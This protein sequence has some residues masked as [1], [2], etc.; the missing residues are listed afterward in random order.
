MEVNTLKKL[1]RISLLLS[2]MLLLTINSSLSFSKASS[3]L[4]FKENSWNTPKLPNHYRKISKDIEPKISEP[5]NLKG[6]DTLNISGSGQFS[7]NGLIKIKESIGNH[8]I[9]VVDL[10]EE[11]HGFVNGVAVSWENE[12]NNSNKGLTIEQ[13]TNEENK[14]LLSIPLNV[15]LKFSNTKKEIIPK[16]VQNEMDL[17]KDKIMS[18]VR[19]PVTDGNLPTNETVNYFVDVVKNL[20]ENTWLHFHCKEGIGRTTTFMAMYDIMRNCKDVPLMDI[21]KR[22]V[23]LSTIGPKHAED[24]YS[25]RRYAFLNEFYNKC[26]AGNLNTSDSYIKNSK[27]PKKLFVISE[28]NLSKEEKVMVA[29]LQGV[30]SSVSEEQI[31]I[32]TSGE[33]DYKIWLEDLIQNQNIKYEEVKDPWTLLGNFKSYVKGYVLYRGFD[34]PSINNA[35]TLASLNDSIVVEQKLES[36]VKDFGITTLKGNCIKTDKYW[37]YNN[38]WDKGLNH[39]TVIQ[40][41]PKTTSALRDYAIMSKSLVF[42]EDEVDSPT[43]RESIFKSMDRVSRVLGWGPD[44]H[45]NVTIASKCGVDVIASDFSY[46]LSVLSSYPT[47]L[48]SQNEEEVPTDSDVHFVTFIMSDGDNQQWFLGSNYGSKSWFGHSS[49]DEFNLGWSISPSIYY[50]APTVFNK[51]YETSNE[52]K[53]SIFLAP[54]SG[55]GYIFPSKF[56]KEKLPSYTNRLN[57]Y[58]KEVDQNYVLIL[59]D[60]SFH[61]KE[62]WNNYTNHSN[63]KGL[64]YLNYKKSD[65][66]KG[67][68]IWSN[69]K[70]IVSSRN[71]LWEGLEDEKSLTNIINERVDKGYT[72]VKSQNAYTFIYVH[73]W[74]KTTSNVENVVNNLSKNPKIKVV[75]PTVFMELIEKNLVKT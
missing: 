33:P 64:F 62:L 67:E 22:Q 58:M 47:K 19:V 36:K 52:S 15:P 59:D 8:H 63:I 5:I 37:A 23:L 65:D 71:L 10:R 3:D 43:L 61:N 20:P 40:L 68:I 27:I 60:D 55:N 42:Y 13:I 66:Y 35:T 17:T 16:T 2:L 57:N 51:Y 9:K 54:P 46:N 7:E 26:K 50:L 25:G 34:N 53:H 28:D 39:S 44:E 30:V 49:K 14:L 12:L 31:Y 72:D 1:L 45:T 41:S 18:Y 29:T 4:K 24:F 21:I 73:V 6:L 69:N 38:L 70:P 48:M 11:S 75:T 74:S 32:L 56:P